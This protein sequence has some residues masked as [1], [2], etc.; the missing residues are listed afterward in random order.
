L[1]DDALALQVKN[2]IV[3]GHLPTYRC[4]LS[5]MLHGQIHNHHATIGAMTRAVESSHRVEVRMVYLD[6]VIARHQLT[7]PWVSALQ[8]GYYDRFAAR[9]LLLE[10]CH[11][12]RRCLGILNDSRHSDMADILAQSMDKRHLVIEAMPTSKKE[13]R[14]YQQNKSEGEE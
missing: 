4:G 5:P 1:L 13:Q 9:I 7:K 8:I 2:I 6:K 14:S 10:Q 12:W 11:K 3:G